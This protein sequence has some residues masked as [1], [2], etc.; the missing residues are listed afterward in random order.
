MP[1]EGSLE[2]AGPRG[3]SR[4]GPTPAKDEARARRLL[5]SK[6]EY[7]YDPCFDRPEAEAELLPPMPLAYEEHAES[8]PP[9]G[10]CPYMASLFGE[11]TL[12]R[13]DE[14]TYLFLKMNYLKYRASKLREAIDPGCAGAADLD[15]IERLQLEAREV[16]NRI[17]RGKLRLV[18]SIAKRRAAGPG[19]DLFDLVGEGNL[20]L[21][22]AV[23]K[24]DVSLGFRFST[25]V[26]CSITRNLARTMERESAHQRRLV[27]SGPD[28]FERAGVE[29]DDDHGQEAPRDGAPETVRLMLSR[30]SDRE[31][32][33]I[34]GRFGLGGAHAKNLRQLGE[35]LGITK[36]R[37]RQIESRAREKLREF[38][39]AEGLGPT[40]A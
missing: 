18:V 20:T 37:V 23:E 12:S 7:V 13:P 25:Y 6:L 22:L 26:S 4:P 16:R 36:E 31:Q 21:I 15:E 1:H 11:A 17:L 32:G 14:E 38:A 34:V 9:D 2:T 3:L 35:E 10:M 33:I 24:F 8:R 5:S 40:A 29:Q 30:L 39:R 28:F 27:T 19:R